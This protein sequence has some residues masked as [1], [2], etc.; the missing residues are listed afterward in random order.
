MSI[1]SEKENMVQNSDSQKSRRGFIVKAATVAPLIATVSSRP[2]WASN[3]TSISGNLSG[4]LSNRVHEENFYDGCS[5]GFWHKAS[6][7]PV[8]AHGYTINSNTAFNSI[9]KITVGQN[10]YTA[11]F[12]AGFTTIINQ[13]TNPASQVERFAAACFMNSLADPNYPYAPGII[14]D[15][16]GYY[17]RGEITASEAKSV[18]EN[19]VHN[20]TSNGSNPVC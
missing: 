9:F 20:G 11:L 7:Y 18:L 15:F 16:Y 6:R 2:V 10:I 4:N 3:I 17:H 14:I 13:S 1:Q 19:L 8:S 5:P 12:A